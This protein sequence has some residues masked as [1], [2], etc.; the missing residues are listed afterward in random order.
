MAQIVKGTDGAI[1]YVDLADAKATGLKFASV[2]EQGGQVRRSRPSTPPRPPA[3]ASTVKDDLTFFVGW[4][5]GDAAYPIAAQTWIIVYAKQ[6]DEAKGEALKCFVNYILPT[7]RSWPRRSTT[8]R[9]RGLAR[10]GDRPARQDPDRLIRPSCTERGGGGRL[11]SR[12]RLLRTEPPPTPGDAS[13]PPLRSISEGKGRQADRAFRWLALRGRR[14]LVLVILG[15][16]AVV[17]DQGGAGRPSSRWGSSFLFTTRLVARRTT[18]SV[19]SA[20]IYGTLL[21]LAHR[22]AASPCR[23]ASAS[24]CSS[25]RWRRRWLQRP[26]RVR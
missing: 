5:D 2:Q 24:R 9:C 15:L 19:R 11:G 13:W 7:A 4:A 8:P 26:D 18:S 1:G 14:L 22:P 10:Q 25:P 3:T 23:S 16:I 20:F 12:H 17:D 21:T 6:T